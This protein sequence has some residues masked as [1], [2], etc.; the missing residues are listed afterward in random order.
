MIVVIL[1]GEGSK[2][3]LFYTLDQYFLTDSCRIKTEE[4]ACSKF[5]L[6]I[7]RSGSVVLYQSR[8]ASAVTADQ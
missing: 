5:D 1:S 8:N 3:L 2:M 6:I 7:C 4:C